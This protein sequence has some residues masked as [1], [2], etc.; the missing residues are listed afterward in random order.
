MTITQQN[1]Y[2]DAA[3]ALWPRASLADAPA[4]TKVSGL[5]SFSHG[6][7]PNALVGQNTDLLTALQ[8]LATSLRARSWANLPQANATVL[9]YTVDVATTANITLSGEQTI[10]G[11]LTSG[12]RVLVK[13][14]TGDPGVTQNGIYVSGSG[15]WTRATDYNTSA[16]IANSLVTA[17][18]G[19]I[20]AYSTWSQ[21]LTTVVVGTTALSFVLDTPGSEWNAVLVYLESV[22]G[23]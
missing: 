20:G 15:A 9:N 13:N 2:L 3:L 14:K 18:G 11:V 8:S 1:T 17:T 5:W 7:V 10:D 4:I 12:S 23:T 19:T 6:A 16:E 21:P 22:I